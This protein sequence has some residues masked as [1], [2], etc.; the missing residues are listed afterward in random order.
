[1]GCLLIRRDALL[2]F[3][4]ESEDYQRVAPDG[5]F[6]RYCSEHGIKQMARLDVVCK[7]IKVNGEVLVPDK[8][9]GWRREGRNVI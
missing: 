7:H 9:A 4:F 1:M 3:P 2:N 8:N 5:A 6:M